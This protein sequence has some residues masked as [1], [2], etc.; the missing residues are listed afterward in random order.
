[1]VKLPT[2]NAKPMGPKPMGLG[3]GKPGAAMLGRM[4]REGMPSTGPKPMGLGR[5]K[6]GAAMPGR[7]ARQGMN[8]PAVMP[9]RAPLKP[10][11]SRGAPGG[12]GYSSTPNYTP[13][14]AEIARNKQEGAA[15]INAMSPMARL[16]QNAPKF[17]G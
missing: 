15:R 17:K 5:G 11:Q 9:S 7:T 4:A 2:M 3:R 8:S 12:P 10:A 13:S 1:M 6:P 16:S 14:A